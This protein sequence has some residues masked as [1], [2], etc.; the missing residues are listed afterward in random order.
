MLAALLLVSGGGIFFYYRF[1]QAQQARTGQTAEE[2]YAVNS[3][4]LDNIGSLNN[5]AAGGVQP[6]DRLSVNGDLVVGG[7]VS[8]SAA[9][10]DDIA[11]GLIG[12]VNLQAASPGTQQTGNINISGV[13]IAS[14]LQGNGSGLTGLNASNFTAGTVEDGRLSANVTRLGQTIPLSALQPTILSSLNG[15]SNNGGN[16]DIIGGDNIS[17]ASDSGGKIITIS[18]PGSAGDISGVTAGD[19]LSGGGTS[20]SVSLAVDSSVARA[21]GAS[22]NSQTFAGNNQK[23]QNIANSTTAFQIQ[24]AAGASNLFVA[25]TTNSRLA[26]NQASANYALDVNGD[27]NVTNGNTFRIGG[28]AICTSGGCTPAGGS[29]GYI[30]NGT[31]LQAAANFNIESAATGSVGGKIKGKSGQSADLFQLVDGNSNVI[32]SFGATGAVSLKTSVDSLHAFSLQNADGERIL[33]VVTSNTAQVPITALQG[34]FNHKGSHILGFLEPGGFVV[35]SGAS[36]GS[37]PAATYEYRIAERGFQSGSISSYSAAMSSTPTTVTTA[38]STSVNT[39][40]WFTNGLDTEEGFRIYRTINGGI[41]WEYVDVSGEIRTLVDNGSNYTWLSLGSSPSLYQVNSNMN[42]DLGLGVGS[43]VVYLGKGNVTAAEIKLMLPTG[44]LNVDSNGGILLTSSAVTRV[45][46]NADSTT[47]FQV[48]N[49]AGTKY[50]LST[51]T[52]NIRLGVGTAAPTATLDVRPAAVGEL[53]FFIRQYA[54]ST[55]DLL[56]FQNSSSV[57]VF[58][59]DAS[60]HLASGESLPGV[61]IVGVDPNSG[62]DKGDT[63]NNDGPLKAYSGGGL[64]LNIAAG[65]AYSADINGSPTNIKRCNLASNTTLNMGDNS[66]RYIYVLA[67]GADSSTGTTCTFAQGT[68]PDTFNAS[69]P[70]VVIAKVVTSGGSIT[71]VSDTRFFIGGNLTYVQ[72]AAAV[73]PGMIVKADTG[74]NNQVQ[75][76]TS[77][78]DTGVEGIV[79]IGNNGAGRAIM[80]TSG[81]AWVQ[82]VSSA[83]RANCA[84][85]STSAGLVNNVTAA[86]NACVGRVKTNAAASTPSVLVQLA[87]N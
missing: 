31:S 34:Y 84:G 40:D 16:I 46:P 14:N 51:D 61:P 54:S 48:Q 15:V 59:I 56:Q 25:D 60:G 58:N 43:G 69:K 11:S 32:A 5:Q 35:S 29:S 65:S 24:N 28:T 22:A 13:V 12:K 85:T 17:V 87:P 4:P 41:S 45:A 57:T 63:V 64:T 53:G 83:T 7:R 10:I 80:M 26:V 27:I 77:A 68:A 79:V 71:S 47:V 76:T 78:A 73:E 37:L 66:T 33:N 52:T 70:T 55:A 30:Q 72:T 75:T 49:E 9:A 81:Q 1:Y 2:K 86:V 38:G 20:G 67:G 42:M 3:I 62:A 6:L 23:F 8:L 50:A 36:G 82:A 39:L 44:D 21:S 19:G 18:T 74:N